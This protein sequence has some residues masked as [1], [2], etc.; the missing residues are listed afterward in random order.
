MQ[1]ANFC[2][3]FGITL[4]FERLRMAILNYKNNYWAYALIISVSTSSILSLVSTYDSIK[5]WG[6]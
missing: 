4:T 3:S 1:K 2:K 5:I 6:S